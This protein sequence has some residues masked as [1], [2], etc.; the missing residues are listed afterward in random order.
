MIARR[1]SRNFSWRYFQKI[2]PSYYTS[3]ASSWTILYAPYV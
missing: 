1:I 3:A 2:D